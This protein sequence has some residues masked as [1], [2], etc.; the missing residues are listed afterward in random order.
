MLPA[1]LGR[2]LRRFCKEQRVS[3]TQVTIAA[4]AVYFKK[5]TG[6]T[7]F[8]FGVPVH[9][10]HTGRQ[11]RIVG[12]FGKVM[13]LVYALPPDVCVAG[14]LRGIRR[15]QWEAYRHASFPVVQIRTVESMHQELYQVLINHVVLPEKDLFKGLDC[16]VVEWVN[17]RPDV[18]MNFLWLDG[19]ELS[20]E[21]NFQDGYFSAAEVAGLVQRLMHIFGQFC[22]DAGGLADRVGIVLPGEATGGDT[23]ATF[24]EREKTVV[25]LFGERV[26]MEPER[27]A[28]RCGGA[29][30]N[31]KELGER[32]SRMARMLWAKGV[33]RGTLVPI[34]MERGIELVI[35][36]LAIWKA[37][38]AYVPID[39][40]L[41]ADRKKY[42]LEDTGAVLVVSSERYREELMGLWGAEVV[43]GLAAGLAGGATGL[44]AGLT[45]DAGLP[46]GMGP[47]AGDLAY[48]I[49]TSGSTGK[50]KGVMVE[51][52]NLA[53]FIAGMNVAL[54]IGEEDHLL[55]ITSISFDISILELFWTLCRGVLVT[56]RESGAPINNFN[57]YLRG[58]EGVG[59]DFGLFF[60]SSG[61][62]KKGKD[63][64]D[65]LLRSARFADEHGFSAVWLPERHFH[66][67]GGL[68]PNPAVLAAGLATNTKR[69]A[70]RA[71]SVVLPLN[72]VVRVAEEW[73]VVDNLSHGRVSLSVAAGWHADDFILMPQHYANRRAVMQEQVTMLK[74][75]WRG[76]PVR[77]VN[78]LG[79]EV[80]VSIFP[81]PVQRE[82]PV[83]VTAAGNPETFRYAGMVG[84]HLLTHLLGQRVEDLAANI[85][86]YKQA[87]VDHGHAVADK[88][89]AVMLH[90]YIGDDHERVKAE[91]TGPFKSYLR[92]SVD[93]LKNLASM[94]NLE[95]RDFGDDNINGL[96]EIAFERYWQRSALMGTKESCRPLLEQLA[97]VGVTEIACLID[98]GVD[99]EKALDNLHF[100]RELKDSFA[101]SA[102]TQGELAGRAVT[103]LQVTPSYLRSL[104]DDPGSQLFLKG[105]QH[106]IVGGEILSVDLVSKLKALTAASIY[107]VYGPTET[108]IWS[109][110]AVID[111]PGEKISIGRPIA[112][113]QIYIR[114]RL[115]GLVPAGEY[116]E[117]YIG[118]DGV[119][120]G[121]W[122]RPALTE[123][124]FV[125][126]AYRAASGRLY[127]TGDI[128]RR[129]EDGSLEY[130]GRGDDQ[131]KVR[132][133][134]IEPGEIVAAMNE[135][136]LV[137]AAVVIGRTGDA[138]VQLVGYVVPGD[139]Y[140]RDALLLWLRGH[141]P[142][143]AVPALW[144]ELDALP[145]TVNGKIDRAALPMPGPGSGPGLV[146]AAAYAAPRGG[147]EALLASIWSGLLGRE[148]VGVDDNFFDLGGDSIISIQVVSRAR[149]EGIVMDV[150]DIFNHQT[151]R[152][153]AGALESR[154][155]AGSHGGGE[156]GV[157]E[158]GCGLLPIQHWC[159]ESGHSRVSHYNQSL[160]LHV[161]KEASV[162]RLRV[163]MEMLLRQHDSLRFAYDQ[164]PDGGWHQR[165]GSAAEAVTPELFG[166]VNLS[167]ARNETELAQRVS[168][169]A[170]GCQAELDIRRGKVVKAV[171]LEM[172]E[173]VEENR[174]V[175]VIHHLS[176]DGVSWRI[177]LEDLELLLSH[178]GPV[179]EAV[180]G[181][182]SSSYRQWY[183]RLRRLRQGEVLRQ[184]LTYW[185]GVVRHYDK[186]RRD[187]EW[188]G[189][190]RVKDSL[191]F[192]ESLGRPLTQQLVM[193]SNR[194]YQTEIND[195]L[196]AALGRT[197]MR[198][199]GTHEVVIGLEGHGR[200]VSLGG[201]DLS[202]TVGWFTT[203]YPV[204]LSGRAAWDEGGWIRSIKE[205]LRKTPRRGIGYGVLRYMGDSCA[206]GVGAADKA[207]AG[208]RGAAGV[209]TGTLAGAPLPVKAPWDILFNYLGQFDNLIEGSRWFSRLE[210]V[211][212]G[213]VGDENVLT[214]LLAVN[215][216]I[217]HGELVLDWRFSGLH[218]D[219]VTVRGLCAMY[220]EELESMI[221]HCVGVGQEDSLEEAD[222]HLPD[223]RMLDARMPDAREPEGD[224]I[225]NDIMEF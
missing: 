56:I 84:A 176:V 124:R 142:E 214:D 131:V 199:G 104:V 62:D 122:N 18:P 10:R 177:L 220:L 31:Y 5:T 83:W 71:G 180:L 87:L 111:S 25:D 128:G 160:V 93:L 98:F 155:D 190:V 37:G 204:M 186:L 102:R 89:I 59:M 215:G 53:N 69:L 148:R 118:G 123:E 19:K 11:R 95:G 125:P 32:S 132:G 141:L 158:G 150:V 1:E 99:E 197:L 195:I 60:F 179:T 15:A 167:D 73:A 21:V 41:P 162:E 35:S 103:A 51:H 30:I 101:G 200:E 81:T 172:P 70:L 185:Q 113:T 166:R 153:L 188:A 224:Q 40:A 163:A 44:A 151:I 173:W 115:G 42:M 206:V 24:Y 164:Q 86:L 175:M 22:L 105:L 225:V 203:M 110:T 100:L 201:V 46:E 189:P 170:V 66:A 27:T 121:Y 54:G 3:L 58:P 218:Y 183:E 168:A 157:L 9:N 91:V 63:K 135:S 216:V 17:W 96:L 76:E 138:G 28:M 77:R 109:T 146:A 85:A 75:L 39:P 55:A 6:R 116:G 127:R 45:E 213:V 219:E 119:A 198:W 208:A 174:L 94:L 49:Y 47:A 159:L 80:A 79:E 88:K 108:T 16:G 4:W 222:G 38:G 7:M 48:L 196:L 26:A 90:T 184:E 154:S 178:P 64:Y 194:A 52:G 182:K 14:L 221:L 187:R 2:G 20:L 161:S 209:A 191:H 82:L 68:F 144:V 36:L 29:V 147:V 207:G 223:A 152:L 133:Y 117:L 67:F 107:N 65:F 33:R 120:R 192:Q 136:G 202:R 114:D 72:D 57:R 112:N 149:R 140:S 137:K 139:G 74:A 134:R 210:V 212:D 12:P 23:D 78:G 61:D 92:S 130:L 165:Y 145:L 193:Y 156:T 13:P 211:T 171:L 43:T 8:T 205:Q 169:A 126:D 217:L 181:A 34:C 106:L 129:L 97:A 143:Y 50:P